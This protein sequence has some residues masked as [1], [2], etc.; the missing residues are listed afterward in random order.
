[1][2]QGSTRPTAVFEAQQTHA[3]LEAWGIVAGKL[4]EEKDP[5]VLVESS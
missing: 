3:V 4:L 2:V 5:G 1:M